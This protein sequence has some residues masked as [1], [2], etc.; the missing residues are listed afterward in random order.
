MSASAKAAKPAAR[1]PRRTTPRAPS[2]PPI[3][4]KERIIVATERLIAERGID[5]PLRDIAI[6]A[7]QRNN[8]AVQYHFGSR[9]GLIQAVI[10]HR[11][12][13]VEQRRLERLTELELAG[14]SADVRSLVSTL[15]EPLL[16]APE[17]D[18]ATHHLRF[19]EQVRTHPSLA[20]P[21]TLQDEQRAAV[22]LVMARLG[23][24]LESLPKDER[25][26]RL[27]ALP[28]VMFALLAD[29]ERMLESGG[30]TP[31]RRDRNVERIV[32]TLTTMLTH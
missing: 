7:D 31:R 10:D 5:V 9:D 6:A 4:S 25:E 14:S 29:H 15:V 22:R 12:P 16:E 13:P 1:S 24:S 26:W 3:S 27:R 8:S 21:S 30:L 23:R 18:R 32:D 19:L 11:T 2:L 17:L 28:A 20:D